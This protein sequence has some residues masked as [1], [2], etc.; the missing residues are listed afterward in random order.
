MEAAVHR[1]DGVGV[2]GGEVQSHIAAPAGDAGGLKADLNAT[3]EVGHADAIGRAASSLRV[4]LHRVDAHL[5]TCAR[6][7]G[8]ER[9]IVGIAAV[10]DAAKDVDIPVTG[11]VED[12]QVGATVARCRGPG[13]TQ[14]TNDVVRHLVGMRVGAGLSDSR[15]SGRSHDGDDTH[16][17]H[18]LQKSECPSR[19]VASLETISADGATH[20]G[21]LECKCRARSAQTR[22]PLILL[23]SR[24]TNALPKDEVTSSLR[25]LFAILSGLELGS[26]FSE[27]HRGMLPLSKEDQ[28][29]CPMRRTATLRRPGVAYRSAPRPAPI[30]GG[31]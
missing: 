30:R 16:N 25:K 23:K 9:P 2:V 7:G 18:Q 3:R 17:H 4:A 10:V 14:R 21:L 15:C 6:A 29:A 19:R 11:A 5:V 20:A 22:K 28:A 1:A 13:P 8:Q 27:H 26:Q 24:S 12:H 31:R